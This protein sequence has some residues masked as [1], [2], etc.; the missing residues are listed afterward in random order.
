[1]AIDLTRQ[2]TKGGDPQYNPELRGVSEERGIVVGIVKANVHGSHMGVIQVFI[3]AMST[4]E[5]DKSQWRTVRYCTPF[6]S[7]VESTKGANNQDS[8]NDTKMSAGIVTPPP[9]LGTTVLCFFPG[10]KNSEGYYFACVPDTYMLQS[11]PEATMVDDFEAGSYVG[12]ELNDKKNNPNDIVNWKTQHR[13]ED[14]IT[15]K[16][17]QEQGLDRDKVRGLNNSSYMRESPS[18][19]V[20]ISSKGRRIDKS[21]KDFLIQNASALKDINSSDETVRAGLLGPTARRKGHSI[22]LDDGDIDGNSNQIRLRTSTGHQILM[23]DNEGIMYVGNAKG[24]TWIELGNQGTLDVFATDSI[25]FRSKNLNFHADENIKFHSTGYTQLVSEQ[26]VHLQSGDDFVISSAG[27]A[28]V[29]SKKFSVVASGQMNLSGGATSSIKASGIMSVSGSLVMLQ[30]PSLGSQSAKPVRMS[31]QLD[32]KFSDFE[33]GASSNNQINSPGALGG[34]TSALTGNLTSIVTDSL[35][36]SVNDVTSVLSPFGP[37]GEN[38][39]ILGEL[40]RVVGTAV[41]GPVG[42]EIGSAIGKEVSKGSENPS[43]TVR[44]GGNPGGSQRTSGPGRSLST[45]GRYVL[46][47]DSTVTTTVDRLVSHEP[48]VGHGEK[49]TPTAYSGGLAGGGGIG[50]AFSIISAGFSLAKSMPPGTFGTV[51]TGVQSNLSNITNSSTFV[52]ASGIDG[53]ATATIPKFD[54]SSVANTTSSFDFGS[55]GDTFTS[56]SDT[57]GTKIQSFTDAVGDTIGKYGNGITGTNITSTDF[58]GLDAFG[59]AGGDAGFVGGF[60][61]ISPSID[62]ISSNIVGQGAIGSSWADTLGD[63]SN[64][65]LGKLVTDGSGKIIDIAKTVVA[66]YETALPEIQKG[67]QKVGTV[68]NLMGA[69]TKGL[70][71]MAGFLLEPSVAGISVTDV[72][73]QVDSGFSI[74]DL[75]A[76]DIQALNAGFVKIAGSNNVTNFIDSTTKTVGKYGFNVNQLVDAGYVRP[77]ALFNDQLAQSSV[78]TGKDNVSSLNK[79]LINAGIQEQVNQ[80]TIA[81]NYQ[82]LINNGAILPTDG[83]KEIMALLTGSAKGNA[84]IV[85]QIR[86]GNVNIEGLVRNTTGIPSGSDTYSVIKDALQTGSG[87]SE[88]VT[89]LKSKNDTGIA[90]LSTLKVFQGTL[91]TGETLENINGVSYVVP[92]KP[93]NPYGGRNGGKKRDLDQRI[94]KLTK[95]QDQLLRDGNADNNIMSQISEKLTELF[96]ERNKL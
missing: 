1:M 20:G 79:F 56:I 7:R 28:G 44:D 94:A 49:N 41:A 36:G 17:L 63:L 66:D 3:P 65:S 76:T 69:D 75:E 58:P 77:E 78:W 43:G 51:G 33:S 34:V 74:G 6:Y 72:V 29:T 23:N 12:G 59:G 82:K 18:E 35:P 42:G 93:S 4:D 9:D 67:L 38:S 81:S 47:R 84:D 48:F 64:S 25:N 87:A 45:G 39:N 13:P 40:G 24:T 52:G 22:T 70:D 32:P 60:S 89:T 31:K 71:K 85:K 14:F 55:L 53:V 15:Q 61:N 90:D 96:A 50:A 57:I 92:A 73:K 5:S 26:Q 11:V 68:A 80:Q 46:S 88:L 10:G 30:G 95:D 54:F 19:L 8:F 91:K 2:G 16:I 21:G 37:G 86:F 62:S 27:D 83:K